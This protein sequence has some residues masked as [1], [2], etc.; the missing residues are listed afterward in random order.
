VADEHRLQTAELRPEARLGIALRRAREGR[1][2]S[3]RALAR[4]LCPSHSTLVEYERGDRLAPLDVVEAYEAELGVAPGTLVALHERARLELYGEDRSHRQT[5]VLGPALPAPNQLPA[6]T[7]HFVGRNEELRQLTVLLD[8]TTM[9]GG[10]PVVISAING[11]AGIGKTAL[12][13]HW[14]HHAS[15]WF[16]DGQ[17]YVNLRGFD[18]T[19]T[20][21]QP[22]EA[23]RDSWSTALSR[24]GSR[25][26]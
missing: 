12:A 20:P 19:G 13:V 22:A 15:Q 26:R 1:A 14:A 10:G 6:H 24:L 8:T 16:P 25:P 5:Y 9:Q 23:I 4:K 3:L 2:V 18:P 11:T 7:P 21:M 17:L